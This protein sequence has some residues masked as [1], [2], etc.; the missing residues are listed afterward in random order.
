MKKILSLLIYIVIIVSNVS[1]AQTKTPTPSNSYGAMGIDCG[2][3]GINLANGQCKFN[4]YETL[5]IRRSANNTSPI[6][7]VQDIVLSATFFIGTVITLAIV[8]AGLLF[9][10]AGISG[11]D[12]LQGKAKSGMINAIIGLVIVMASYMII[13]LVQFIVRGG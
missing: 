9:I 4:I 10:R 11:N 5:G 2:E 13:R 12:S 6:L 1:L 8:V 3:G 7:F